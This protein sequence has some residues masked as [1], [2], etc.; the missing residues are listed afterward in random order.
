MFAE[1]RKNSPPIPMLIGSALA[2]CA[3]CLLAALVDVPMLG[4]VFALSL[5][6][7]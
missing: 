3:M 4:L 7:I 2:A 1:C 5:I 6:H